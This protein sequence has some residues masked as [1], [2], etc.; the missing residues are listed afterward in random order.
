M[1]RIDEL[2]QRLALE[3]GRHGNRK[4]WLYKDGTISKESGWHNQIHP[5]DIGEMENGSV[6][7]THENDIIGDKYFHVDLRTHLTPKQRSHI[8]KQIVENKYD[9]LNRYGEY[10]INFNHGHNE[11][12]TY[13][14]TKKYFDYHHTYEPKNVT[15]TQN[16]AGKLKTRLARLYES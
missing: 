15:H 11:K 13:N 5:D 12:D 6:K 7:I 8:Q 16:L 9:K 4:Y 14:S 1:T 2:R 3:G 10:N